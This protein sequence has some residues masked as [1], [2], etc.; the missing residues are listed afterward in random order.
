MA[1]GAVD[2]LPGKQK[3]NLNDK[4]TKRSHEMNLSREIF[5]LPFT[6]GLDQRGAKN[7]LVVNK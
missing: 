7:Y 3:D 4:V 2:F 1:K 5:L 6:Y